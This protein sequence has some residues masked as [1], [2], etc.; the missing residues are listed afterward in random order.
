MSNVIKMLLLTIFIFFSSKAFGI[1]ACDKFKWDKKFSFCLGYLFSFAMFFITEFSVMFYKLSTKWLIL[2]GFFYIILCFIMLIYSIKNKELLKFNKSEIYSLL[3]SLIFLLGYTYFVDF[4]YIDTHDSYFYSVLTNSA[5][6]SKGISISDPYTGLSNIA[7]FYK[8]MSYYYQSSFYAKLLSI[9]PASLVLIWCYSFLNLYF[10]SST[11]LSIVQIS[12]NKNINKILSTFFLTIVLSFIKVPFNAVHL[13]TMVLPVWYFFLAYETIINKKNYL[14]AIILIGIASISLSSTSLFIIL[15][16]TYLFFIFNCYFYR[17]R[18]ITIYVMCIPALFLALLYIFEATNSLIIFGAGI[19]L[20]TLVLLLLK[21]KKIDFL[22][23]KL[24]K[25]FLI[26]VPLFLVVLPNVN[27]I[28]NEVVVKLFTQK[29]E[30]PSNE[31]ND[32]I[33]SEVIINEIAIEDFSNIESLIDFEDNKHSTAMHYVYNKPTSKINTLLIAI[34]HSIFKYGGILFLAIYGTFKKRNEAFFLF[35]TY[36]ITFWNPFIIEGLSMLTLGLQ[37]RISLAI[38]IIF[39]LIGIAYFFEMLEKSLTGK[40]KMIFTHF[41]KIFAPCYLMLMIFSLF[42]YT[43]LFKNTEKN[44][45]V[46]TK[47]PEGFNIVEEKLN[48]HINNF[49]YKPRVF[50]TA[51]V[52]NVTMIDNNPDS[53]IKV[54]NSKEYMNYFTNNTITT[55]III[56]A[57]FENPTLYESITNLANCDIMKLIREYGIDIIVMKNVLG[58]NLEFDNIIQ[59]N[60]KIIFKSNE[61]L[62]IERK[63]NE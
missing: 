41:L 48:K 18:F 44:Y 9:K 46:L 56:N 29:D 51:S 54:I 2:F 40:L 28:K 58:Q 62:I 45:D 39:A 12:K 25:I 13:M 10:I 63:Y 37:G 32:N 30:L 34:T 1:Y 27:E 26:L 50:F 5:A 35:I 22:I 14:P 61:A 42:S 31:I 21:L 4:G 19:F 43:F 24:G 8:Y 23:M 15:P 6:S 52:F 55:K 53:K 3:L 60:F 16:I 59:N 36:V 11:A 7:N 38:N 17:E 47:I 57:F 49:D 33:S 20:I